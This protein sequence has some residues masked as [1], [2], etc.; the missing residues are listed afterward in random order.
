MDVWRLVHLD[1]SFTYNWRIFTGV[2]EH[3][4]HIFFFFKHS[5]IY[6]W[7]WKYTCMHAFAILLSV[8]IAIS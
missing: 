4:F 2:D 8:Y 3:M 1:R 7:K 5:L 6:P